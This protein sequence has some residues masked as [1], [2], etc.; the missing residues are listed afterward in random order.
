MVDPC[1]GRPILNLEPHALD[2]AAEIR[3]KKRFVVWKLTK[4]IGIVCATTKPTLF[5]PKCWS[6]KTILL[7]LALPS[8]QK[9]TRSKIGSS[10]EGEVRV[11]INFNLDNH[12]FPQYKSINACINVSPR[13]HTKT[14]NHCVNCAPCPQTYTHDKSWDKL[15]GGNC[16]LHYSK[17]CSVN[18]SKLHPDG[19]LKLAE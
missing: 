4:R 6:L 1:A 5:K 7:F 3:Q 8:S 10:D 2:P 11:G 9:T 16:G 18:H 19:R 12:D 14:H 17:R 13:T 15:T